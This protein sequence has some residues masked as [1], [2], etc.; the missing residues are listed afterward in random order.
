MDRM[1]VRN[2]LLNKNLKEHVLKVLEYPSRTFEA[3][4][5]I[6]EAAIDEKKPSKKLK[7]AVDRLKRMK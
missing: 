1:A 2:L 3:F 6:I 5:E 4:C 7:R